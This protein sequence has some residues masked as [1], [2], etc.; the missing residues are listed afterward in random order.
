VLSDTNKISP[1]NQREIDRWR[2]FG[3]EGFTGDKDSPI[4][5]ACQLKASGNVT[6][7][8]PPWNGLIGKLD[9]KE[10]SAAA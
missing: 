5:L 9:E 6:L 8:I 1:P 10:K 2:Y 3:Y 7:V 4:R